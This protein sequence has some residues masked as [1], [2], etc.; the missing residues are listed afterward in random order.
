M[1]SGGSKKGGGGGGLG[2][3]CPPPFFFLQKRRLLAKTSIKR[4][5]NLS[6]LEM[7]ILE[8]QIFKNVCG[9]I[10]SHPPRKLAPLALVG[11]PPPPPLENPGSAPDD[12]AKTKGKSA[13]GHQWS[14]LISKMCVI[15]QLISALSYNMK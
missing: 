14:V 9:G 6:H 13:L 4:V 11:A 12:A 10:P 5:R 7:V 3:L 1:T 8:I 2:G 15:L